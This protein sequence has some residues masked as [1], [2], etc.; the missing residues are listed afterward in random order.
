MEKKAMIHKN[1]DIVSGIFISRKQVLRGS[2]KET[3]PKYFFQIPR[4]YIS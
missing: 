3:S 2:Q 1:D 4:K